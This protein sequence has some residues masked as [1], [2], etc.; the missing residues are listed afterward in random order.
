MSNPQSGFRCS[1]KSKFQMNSIVY[2]F[3]LGFQNMHSNYAFKLF[4]QIKKGDLQNAH[5]GIPTY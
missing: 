5:T 2:A 1:S 4:I 3:G